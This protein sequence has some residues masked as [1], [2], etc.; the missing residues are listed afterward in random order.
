M[1]WQVGSDFLDFYS[2]PSEFASKWFEH[3][4]D[5]P[6]KRDDN[7]YA[8]PQAA[9]AA[10]AIAAVT[11]TPGIRLLS[12][13][14]HLVAGGEKDAQRF[15]KKAAAERFISEL[16]GMAVRQSCSTCSFQPLGN[17]HQTQLARSRASGQHCED[18]LVS[19]SSYHCFNPALLELSVSK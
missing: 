6:K 11:T 1:H 5:S 19:Q 13:W 17:L 12:D 3:A 18:T 8:R 15:S 14:S 16:R 10:S 9:F 7:S 2:L 4:N